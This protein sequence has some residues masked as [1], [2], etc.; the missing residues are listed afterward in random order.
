MADNE[1]LTR[2]ENYFRSEG[3][4]CD[5][6]FL[7]NELSDRAEFWFKNVDGS[8]SIPKVGGQ[9]E[10]LIEMAIAAKIKKEDE[11]RREFIS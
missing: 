7:L 9:I 2:D 10:Q 11:K 4:D 1:F 6:D 8:Y 5:R 3:F